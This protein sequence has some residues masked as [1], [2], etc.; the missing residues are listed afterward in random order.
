[1]GNPVLLRKRSDKWRMCVDYTGLNKACSKDLLP[2][3]S[4]DQVVDFTYGY[5]VLSFFDAYSGYH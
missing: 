5:K 4:I 3:P 1:L 2:L